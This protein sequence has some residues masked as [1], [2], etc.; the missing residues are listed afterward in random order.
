M[1][2]LA[3]EYFS[4]DNDSMLDDETALKEWQSACLAERSAQVVCKRSC[5]EQP[6]QST[7]VEGMAGT[8]DSLKALCKPYIMPLKGSH[9]AT[10]EASAF[11]DQLARCVSGAFSAGADLPVHAW[12]VTGYCIAAPSGFNDTCTVSGHLQCQAG[13]VLQNR[14]LSGAVYTLSAFWHKLATRVTEL[15]AKLQDAM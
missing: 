14:N 9:K 11:L 4:A 1:K 15:T 10:N 13:A 8:S 6:W 7:Q 2:R 5:S 12:C 3:E